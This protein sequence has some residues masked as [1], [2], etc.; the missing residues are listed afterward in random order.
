MLQTESMYARSPIVTLAAHVLNLYVTGGFGSIDEKPVSA[1]ARYDGT[2][3][4]PLAEGL[5]ERSGGR[6]LTLR[7]NDLFVGHSQGG[8][9]W[10]GGAWF[11]AGLTGGVSALALDGE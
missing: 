11:S 7:G 2:N 8:S 6:A 10:D 1:I 5:P 4:W 3:W 9:R